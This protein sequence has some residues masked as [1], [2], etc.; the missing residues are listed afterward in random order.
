MTAPMKGRLQGSIDYSQG[1]LQ[2]GG[3]PRPKPLAGATASMR[4]C[5]GNTHAR[6]H[7][8]PMRFRPRATAIV[9]T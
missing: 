5:R 4:F 1:P 7:R 8:P 6:R 9:T 3:L 2:G